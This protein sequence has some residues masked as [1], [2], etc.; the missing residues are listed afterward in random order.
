MRIALSSPV[1]EGTFLVGCATSL[2]FAWALCFQ[3]VAEHW[4]QN[5]AT[6]E[7][8]A[9][10][11]RLQPLNAEIP[12]KLG[13][14]EMSAST[15]DFAGAVLHLQ[16]AVALNPHSSRAWLNLADA[17]AVIDD[18]FRREDAVRHA[19]AAEPKD[20]QVQWEAANLFIT[21]DLDRSLQ[22]LR[23]VVENDPQYAPAAMQVAYA[24]SNNNIEKAM[25][26]VPLAATSRLHLM[27][28]LLERNEFNAADRVWP[29]V[30]ASPGNV[31]ARETFFYFDS[32]IARHQVDR[33]AAAWS[34]VVHKDAALRERLQ[35]DNLL[36][37]GDFEGDLLNGGFGWRYIPTSGVAAT[38][39][40]STF[41]GGTRSLALQIDGEN[42]Q[43]LG[44]RELVKVEPGAQY[45]LSGWLHAEELE[46]AH[47]I[48]IGVNDAYTHSQLW[49]TDDVLGSFPWRQL[50]GTF[51]VPQETTLVEI[52]LMRSPASGHIRGRL[53]VD[54]LRLENR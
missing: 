43:D 44:V 25:L 17:Y 36:H 47:G 42:L 27:R 41:H 53:W 49:M 2:L 33:A 21:T 14:V 26:A 54:D 3:A 16:R 30:I 7:R 19:L 35:R 23:G 18:G 4:L 10:A 28:W 52:S 5:L 9:R 32:L 38:L 39:D 31:S 22:L 51:T 20:T 45:R 8:L 24:A 40:T 11:A 50:D 29:T 37:N 46:A 15:A 6:R 34:E 12:E 13:I 1:R 48:R